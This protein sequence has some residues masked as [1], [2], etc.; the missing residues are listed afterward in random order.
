MKKVYGNILKVVIICTVITFFCVELRFA[1]DIFSI[2]KNSNNNGIKQENIILNSATINTAG[3]GK[4]SEIQDLERLFSVF[5]IPRLIILNFTVVGI[6]IVYALLYFISWII[7][8]K[9][10][11]KNK[12]IVALVLTGIAS[13]IQ[14]IFI[15]YWQQCLIPI[16]GSIKLS[17]LIADISEIISVSLT[18]IILFLNRSQIKETC[19]KNN[20]AGGN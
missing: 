1:L 15:F 3:L 11:N 16:G 2:K 8:N 12:V 19:T 14:I 6:I 18:L 5:E 9:N 10:E 13:I 20:I 17:D 4:E 7:F